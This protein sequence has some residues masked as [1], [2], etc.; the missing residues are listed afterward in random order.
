MARANPDDY[1]DRFPRPEDFE[2]LKFFWE[3]VPATQEMFGGWTSWVQAACEWSPGGSRRVEAHDLLR[4]Q[5]ATVSKGLS[6]R[7]HFTRRGRP[8][9]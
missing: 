1:R 8:V 9:D 7:W 6:G 5:G 2:C 4:T 3:N